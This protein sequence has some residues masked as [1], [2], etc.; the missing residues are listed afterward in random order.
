LEADISLEKMM[1]REDHIIVIIHYVLLMRRNKS[2]DCYPFH[3][4]IAATT[5]NAICVAG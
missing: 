1:M 4:G 5:T 3:G 2:A